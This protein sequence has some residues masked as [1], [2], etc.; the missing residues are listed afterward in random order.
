MTASL[1]GKVS[2][3][4]AKERAVIHTFSPLNGIF[5]PFLASMKSNFT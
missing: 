3:I 5:L 4:N 2:I 1:D